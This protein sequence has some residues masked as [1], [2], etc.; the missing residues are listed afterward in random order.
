MVGWRITLWAAIVVVALLFLYAVR[1]ILAPFVL[2]FLVSFLLDPTIRRL[3]MR[4]YSRGVAVG[5]VFV[6]FFGVL[7]MLGMW[8]TPVISSQLT[9]FRDR[10]ESFSTELAAESHQANFFVRWTPTAQLQPPREE[11]Q[12]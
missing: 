1:S 9:T 2:A 11:S 3:R 12:I 8:L 7:T 6:V 10:I 5:M 4:G